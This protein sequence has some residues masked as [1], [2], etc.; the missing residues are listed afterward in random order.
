MNND[1]ILYIRRNNLKKTGGTDLTNRQSRI[2]KELY[3]TEDF[4]SAEKLAE[5]FGFSV[6]T[7]RNDIAYL[8]KWL[9]EN[10]LGKIISK[11]NAGFRLSI[12]EENWKLVL[13]EING[14]ENRSIQAEKNREYFVVVEALLKQDIVQ[15]NKLTSELYVSRN[16]MDVYLREATEWFEKREI[17]VVKKRGAGISLK[18]TEH[19][20]RLALWSYYAEC[21]MKN[22]DNNKEFLWGFHNDGVEQTIKELERKYGLSF[23]YNGYCKLLFLLSVMVIQVRRNHVNS[24][25]YDLPR[26]GLYYE[27]AQDC[28]RMLDQYYK[29]GMPEQEIQYLQTVIASVELQQIDNL[30]IYSQ[31]VEENKELIYLI[32]ECIQIVEK[33]LNVNLEE[34]V[35]FQNNLIY[36]AV[37]LQYN[38]KYGVSVQ[39]EATDWVRTHYPDIYVAALSVGHILEPKFEKNL[40]QNEVAQITTLIAAAIEQVK[41]GITVC[42]VCDYNIGTSRLLQEQLKKEFPI[43]QVTALLTPRD[44]EKIRKCQ[45]DLIL[46]TVPLNGLQLGRSV[47]FIHNMMGLDEKKQI[48]EYI[49]NYA[50]KKMKLPERKICTSDYS[51][52]KEAY[53]FHINASITKKELIHQMCEKLYQNGVIRKEFEETVFQREKVASTAL[54]NRVAIPHGMPE[55]VLQPTVAVAVLDHPLKWNDVGQAVETVFLL[56]VNLE[57]KFGAKEQIIA[58]YSTLVSMVDHPEE[59]EK[60][61]EL[62]SEKEIQ[63]Y[64]NKKIEEERK[65]DK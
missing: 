9:Q 65:H 34:D 62:K 36:Y 6:K 3:W 37:A 15:I 4:I 5:R 56:A 13:K 7:I 11:N 48:A 51:L 18:T 63:N 23:S 45:C 46:T 27:M 22:T 41:K 54:S 1:M 47:I 12:T 24:D 31:F 43:I 14:H 25:S 52:V 55:Y 50:R 2:L 60:F 35:W 44:K 57:K 38:L 26:A 29:T 28:L 61:H 17:L 8:K 39:N 53:I 16:M 30:Q 32:P 58:F 21:I 19:T 40:S 64:L 10:E 49:K 20:Y 33:I 59:Y 42:I